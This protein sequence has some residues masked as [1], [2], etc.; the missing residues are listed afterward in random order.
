MY[1]DFVNKKKHHELPPFCRYGPDRWPRDK[2]ALLDA[3]KTFFEAQKNLCGLGKLRNFNAQT[4][5]T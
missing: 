3:G 5:G 2:D 4:N 1:T